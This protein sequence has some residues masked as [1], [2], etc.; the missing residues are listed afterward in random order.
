MR[1][2][3]GELSSSNRQTKAVFRLPGGVRGL[4]FTRIAGQR[5]KCSNM[6]IRSRSLTIRKPEP[7][8][9]RRQVK[10]D[11]TSARKPARPVPEF[12]RLE[13]RAIPGE[14]AGA[15]LKHRREAARS[16]LGPDHPR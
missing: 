15:S 8:A 3:S 2:P 12:N 4:R 7:A 16:L 10:R 5:S 11:F 6:L 9:D 1:R 13:R 14:F